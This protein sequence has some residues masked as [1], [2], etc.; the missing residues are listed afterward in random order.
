[1]D[2]PSVK[3]CPVFAAEYRHVARPLPKKNK[4]ERII[5][6]MDSVVTT[7]LANPSVVNRHYFKVGPVLP[8]F[9]TTNMFNQ[10]SD[11]RVKPDIYHRQPPSILTSNI[12]R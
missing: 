8:V 9:P 6:P 2:I 4:L 12:I 7:T 10:I 3:K 1:M 11:F 5:K